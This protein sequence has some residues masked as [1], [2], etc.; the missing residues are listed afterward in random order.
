MLPWSLH[1][2]KRETLI[3]GLF[4]WWGLIPVLHFVLL[5]KKFLFKFC[6][7]LSK[8]SSVSV[9]IQLAMTWRLMQKT[10]SIL[11]LAAIFNVSTTCDCTIFLLSDSLISD[12]HRCCCC[13]LGITIWTKIKLTCSFFSYNKFSGTTQIMKI[14]ND[15]RCYQLL[16]NSVLGKKIGGWKCISNFFLSF[17][18]K[19]C[20][21]MITERNENDT[22]L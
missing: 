7:G 20:E 4:H 8:I 10:I 21:K 22:E 11:C 13:I 18:F 6:F 15:N 5:L 2:C 17:I 9:A 19:F 12:S 16:C 14:V 3:P 1:W